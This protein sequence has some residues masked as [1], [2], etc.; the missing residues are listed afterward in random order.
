MKSWVKCT[1]K[2]TKRPVFLNLD[3]CVW[4]EAIQP[5][6]EEAPATRIHTAAGLIEVV[7]RPEHLV[8]EFEDCTNKVR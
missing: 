3:R 8:S 5:A 4:F 6:G 1:D 7:E 2:T